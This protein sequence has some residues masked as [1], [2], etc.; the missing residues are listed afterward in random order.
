M[1]RDGSN[2]L[3]IEIEVAQP[4]VFPVADQQE[5]LTVAQVDRQAVAAIE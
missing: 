4:A 2:E 3:S 5:R 1:L